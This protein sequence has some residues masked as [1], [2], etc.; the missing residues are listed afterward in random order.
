[1]LN[2][3]NFTLKILAVLPKI[4]SFDR[5]AQTLTKQN[6]NTSTTITIDKQGKKTADS[7]LDAYTT[8]RPLKLTPVISLL[9]VV[10]VEVV[11]LKR[12]A[13]SENF[14]AKLENQLDPTSN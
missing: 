2:G 4:S 6:K 8:Y 12:E 14:R 7:Q 3:G 9:L 1:M 11:L 10:V 13:G 5:T